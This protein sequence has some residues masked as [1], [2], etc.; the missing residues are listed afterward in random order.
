MLLVLNLPLVGLFAKIAVI[1]PQILMP[2]ISLICLVGVYSVRN[3][4]FD[5]WVMIAAG[6]AGY[7]LRSWKYPVAPFIIGVVLGPTTENSLRQT[8][9]M[10]RGD[11]SLTVERPVSLTLLAVTAA[12]LLYRLIVALRG[13]KFAH[14]VGEDQT[15]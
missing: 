11:L 9:M 14:A 2:V 12:F 13:R 1:R 15:L 6:V 4:I 8:L 7:F 3:S 5:V 10:F